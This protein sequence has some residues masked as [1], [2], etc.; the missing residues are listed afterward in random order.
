MDNKVAK[1]NGVSKLKRIDILSF[2]RCPPRKGP[3]TKPS[4]KAIPINPK[5]FVFSAGVLTSANA[6]YAIVIFPD[7][8][9]G[10]ILP[11]K[12]NNKLLK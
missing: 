10:I 3:T 12:R 4:P 8:N 2:A 7:D 9:P 1:T 5:F 6:E 11:M